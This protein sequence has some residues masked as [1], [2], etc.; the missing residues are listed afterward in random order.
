MKSWIP[1]LGF[2]TG[3]VSSSSE[4]ES[5]L[6]DSAGAAGLAGGVFTGTGAFAAFCYPERN[7][8]DINNTNIKYKCNDKMGPHTLAGASSSLELSSL[9]LLSA[10][11]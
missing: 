9:L 5:S 7:T 6:L 1:V 11:F 2:L 8:T 4:D 3:G 10:F